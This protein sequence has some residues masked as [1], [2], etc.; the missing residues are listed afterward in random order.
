MALPMGNT[1]VYNI[2]IPSTKQKLKF[3]PFLVKDQKAL[4]L[5]QQSEDPIVMI[6]TLKGIIKGCLVGEVEVENLSTFDLEY[7]FLQMRAK[8]VGEQIELLFKCD[9]DH[10]EEGNAKA[11]VK[12]NINIDDIKCES[13]EGHSNKINLFGDVG[14]FMKYPSIDIIKKYQNGQ[15]DDSDVAF[16]IIS[17]SIDYIYTNDEVF[18][19][20]DS[21]KEELTEFVNNLTTDQFA[22]VQTFFDTMPK[23]RYKIK[24]DCPVCSKHHESNLEGI[25]S[26][27]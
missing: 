9:E 6:D 1:P 15:T 23:V 14:I 25:E 26:F 20:K 8:S 2:E 16:A 13:L 10:G 12:I 19:S 11:K 24:Y 22:K 3:R 17:E 18:H 4:M 27:F 21:T 7:I 5:A